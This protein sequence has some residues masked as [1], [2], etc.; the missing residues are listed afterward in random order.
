MENRYTH[1]EYIEYVAKQA[2]GVMNRFTYQIPAVVVKNN[3]TKEVTFRFDHTRCAAV[4]D[5]V[6]NSD[7]TESTI[8]R[9]IEPTHG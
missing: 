3:L 7:G 5:I 2:K 4:G 1:A 8:L 9:V 6:A